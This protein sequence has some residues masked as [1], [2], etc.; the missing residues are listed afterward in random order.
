[1]PDPAPKFHCSSVK[2]NRSVIFTVAK[3]NKYVI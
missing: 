2:N 3:I 1:M